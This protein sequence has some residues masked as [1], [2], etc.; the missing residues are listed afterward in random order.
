MKDLPTTRY[1]ADGRAV[2][3]TA[4]FS[5]TTIVGDVTGETSV[6]IPSWILTHPMLSDRAVRLWG[7]MKGALMDV[8]SIPGTTHSSIAAL[9]DVSERTARAAIYELRDAG[10]ITVQET[11]SNNA[12]MG[13]IYY[14]WPLGATEGGGNQLPEGVAADCQ[15]IINTNIKN[16]N[17]QNSATSK[18]RSK[19]SYDEQFDVVWKLYPRHVNK[20]G[21]YKAF[22]A[23]LKKGVKYDDLLAAVKQ[24]AA[25]RLGQDEKYTLY[26]A[27]FFG[28]NERWA[29][30]SAKADE[31]ENYVPDGAEMVA[32][33]IYDLYDREGEW[34]DSQNGEWETRFDNP[35]K[36][37]YIR[38]VN[39]KGQLVGANGVPY[40]LDAQGQ[41]KPLGYWK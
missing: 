12:Q 24:Y 38:P 33:T 4:R 1:S 20:A 30:Y 3:S 32:A 41:R 16:N 23:L 35:A 40:E 7:Y 27:T 9:L 39:S 15:P 28:P 31:V 19:V 21:A 17:A 34:V 18:K 8:L 37:G 6:S 5:G 11:Y 26:A 10:A 29:D 25:Q 13:N 36:Y 14:L 22:C 2:L